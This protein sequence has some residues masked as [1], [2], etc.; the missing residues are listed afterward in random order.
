MKIPYR[1]FGHQPEACEFEL[2]IIQAAVLGLST[3]DR[4]MSSATSLA[5]VGWDVIEVAAIQQRVLSSCNNMV[6]LP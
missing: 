4:M 1:W 6:A 5:R 3:R 2:P